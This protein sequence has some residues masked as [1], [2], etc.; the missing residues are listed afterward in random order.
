MVI[1][2]QNFFTTNSELLQEVSQFILSLNNTM[3]SQNEA[4][5]KSTGIDTYEGY[6]QLL[7]SECDEYKCYDV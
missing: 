6:N 1:D 7:L 3:I 5:M 4:F 2:N